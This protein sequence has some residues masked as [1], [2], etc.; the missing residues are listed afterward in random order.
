MIYLKICQLYESLE[1]NHSRLSKTE[2]ISEFIKNIHKE[3]EIIYLLQGRA[4]SDNNPKEF[5][6]SDQTIIKALE[7]AFG[8]SAKEITK[9]FKKIGDLGEVSVHLSEK[10]K[11]STLFSNNLTT[12]QVLKNLNQIPKLEGKRT[13]EKKIDLIVELLNSASPLETKF[14]IRTLLNDLRIG[15]GSGVIR[16]SIAKAYLSYEE[17]SQEIVQEAYDLSNDFGLVYEK[18]SN[19]K[20]QLKDIEISPGTPIK[21]MLAL[22]AKD[23]E[24][25][26]ERVGKPACLEYKYDGFRMIITKKTGQDVKIYTRRLDEVTNQFPEVKE[27]AKKCINAQDYIIDAEAVGFNKQTKKYMPFQNISQ[28][29]KRKY[30]IEQMSN[31]FPIEINAFDILYLNGLSLIKEPFQKRTELLRTIL[32]P[33]RWKFVAAKQIITS[34]EEEAREFYKKAV[35]EG[36]EGIMIKNLNSPY[37]PGA[38]VGFMLKLKPSLKEF[39]LIITGAEYGTGKR[40]GWLTSFDVSCR[41]A[42]TNELLEIGKVSTGIKEKSEEGTTY[43]YI[44]SI[45]KN[46]INNENGLKVVIKPKIVVSVSYQEIQKSPKYNSGFAL[47]FPRFITLREDRAE[48]DIASIEEVKREYDEQTK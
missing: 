18:A 37:K 6:I 34:N 17:N 3:R 4:W 12:E 22:K 26:F 44:T 2:L 43:E 13:V 33:E 41:D 10:R 29:I 48:T 38:R 19:G 27:Y 42:S 39:D 16:D 30:G 1:K 9:K 14:I 25:G 28:R 45:L 32:R 31:N 40:A 23:I 35:E 47:R 7:R 46:Y 36:E 15:V 20:N 11:Q 24:D 8:I 21:V 5:G